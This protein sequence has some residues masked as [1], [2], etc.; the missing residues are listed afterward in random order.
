MSFIEL[1]TFVSRI[2]S[3]KLTIISMPDISQFA[4]DCKKQNIPH[5][6]FVCMISL[7]YDIIKV[8]SMKYYLFLYFTQLLKKLSEMLLKNIN[9]SSVLCY[10][11]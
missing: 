8:N 5:N 3:I 10:A 9:G 4:D 11:A 2:K 6:R 7:S 1:I